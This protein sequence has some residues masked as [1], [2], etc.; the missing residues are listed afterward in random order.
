MFTTVIRSLTCVLSAVNLG[1]VT[2][3]L[4]L[5]IDIAEERLA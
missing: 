3:A 4:P 2:S 1:Q 5:P